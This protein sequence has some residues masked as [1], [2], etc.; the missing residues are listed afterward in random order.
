MKKTTQNLQKL[1]PNTTAC[2][3]AFLG[4][5]LPG[6][7]V[8]H[9]KQLGIFGMVTR[10]KG[11]LLWKHGLHILSTAR[12]QANSWFQQIRGLCSLYQLPHPISL[13]Q[14]FRPK[15][16]FN[17][18]IK[19][20]VI[21]YWEL[22]LRKK[23]SELKSLQYFKPEFMSLTNPHPIWTSCNS[24]PWQVHKAV[25]ACRMLSGRYLTDQLQ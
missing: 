9:L 6:I 15:T 11:S 1:M 3:V 2:V 7:A 4:G 20:K 18:L 5:T 25:T 10:M 19:A 12:P 17:R 8:L 24:N 13:L 14:E 21:D 16:S 23:A 22:N